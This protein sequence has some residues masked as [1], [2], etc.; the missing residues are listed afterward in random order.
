MTSLFHKRFYPDDVFATV[1]YVSPF[2]FSTADSRFAD[3]LETLGDE[4]CRQCLL[5]FQRLVL[6]NRDSLLPR[7]SAWFS[8]NGFIHPVD[9]I[10][11]F[12]SAVRTYDWSFWQYSE[13]NCA[14]IPGQEASFDE[15]L[16]HLD[17]VVRFRYMT[18]ERSEYMRPWSYQA[19]TQIGYPE[20][21]YDHLAD[22]LTREVGGFGGGYFD[23]LGIDLVYRPETVL[24]IHDWLLTEGNN[25]VYIY[26]GNDPWTAGAIELIGQTNALKVLREGENH[27]VK[28]ADLADPEF[29]L[30]TLERWLGVQVPGLEGLFAVMAE[31]DVDLMVPGRY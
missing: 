21:R 27:G 7:F 15:M 30:A 22:L 6:Q 29:V 18:D 14:G 9:T 16:V 31:T 2:M 13:G 4:S 3:F 23:S 10:G 19:A 17:D 24:D 20:R 5:S 11:E 1:A 25:V 28:I 26:G 8:D 12:E